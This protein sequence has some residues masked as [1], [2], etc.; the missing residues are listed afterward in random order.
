[1]DWANIIL[2][3]ISMSVDAMTVGAVDGVKEKGMRIWKMIIIALTF[4]IFQ[5]GMP[6][7]GYFIGQS[8]RQYVEKYVFWIGFALLMALAIKSFIDWL[9]DFR[10]RKSG[11][12]DEIK[13]EKLNI[14]GLFVQAVATSI[15]ALCIGF[16]YMNQTIPEAMLIFGII[17][18][19]TFVLSFITINFGH[20]FANKLEKWGSLVAAIVFVAIAIKVLI[21]GLL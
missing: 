9:L 20:L 17:G 5:F 6:V 8:F 15:D 2:T 14:G 7:I 11:K 10:K 4:G 16:V 18:I 12:T 1:M 19:T 13:E 21:T 3:S